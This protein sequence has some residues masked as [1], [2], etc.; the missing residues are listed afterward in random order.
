MLSLYLMLTDYVARG[1]ARPAY[2]RLRG[3]TGGEQA[4]GWLIEDVNKVLIQRFLSATCSASSASGVSR[5]IPHHLP[6]PL[7]GLPS[8]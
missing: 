3:A 5:V 4:V 8:P 7:G 2:Q 6:T 1:E